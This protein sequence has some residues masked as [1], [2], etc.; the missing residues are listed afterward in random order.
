MQIHN[1]SVVAIYHIIPIRHFRILTPAI[2]RSNTLHLPSC[3]NSIACTPALHACR[4]RCFQNGQ[5]RTHD[6]AILFYTIMKSLSLN[7]ATRQI[8]LER[9]HILMNHA[10]SNAG[11][12]PR[13]SHRQ[14]SAARRLSTKYRVQMPYGLRMLFCKRCKSLVVPGVTSRVRMGGRKPK[15]IRITCHFCTH[16]YRKIL[17]Q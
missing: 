5:T 8:V 7:P 12:N 1:V 6:V 17:P 13:L 15:S 9:I 3:M 2:P 10:V 16:V 14:A 11:T 4:S